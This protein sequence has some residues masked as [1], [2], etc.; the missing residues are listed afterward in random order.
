MP[1]PSLLR[2]MVSVGLCFVALPHAVLAQSGTLAGTV[3]TD[4]TELRLA[5][6]EVSLPKLDRSA[7]TDSAGNFRFTGLKA[8]V[9]ELVI[10]MVGYE[11]ISTSLRLEEGKTVEGDFLLRKLSTQLAAVEVK[12]QYSVHKM[13]LVEFE[14]R[15]KSQP[16]RFLTADVFENAMG[17]QFGDVLTSRLPA[18]RLVDGDRV[19]GVLAS[20]RWGFPCPVQVAVNGLIMNRPGMPPFNTRDVITDQVIGVEFYSVATTPLQYSGTGN[21]CGTV[22]IWTK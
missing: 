20:M 3:M 8:G 17:R 7:R 19:P 1:S 15:R 5:N 21:A 22:A 13:R 16:G 9:H 12:D 14:E 2:A 4:S 18:V 11:A 10:R 6:A